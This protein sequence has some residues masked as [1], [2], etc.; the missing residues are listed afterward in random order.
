MTAMIA[1][2]SGKTRLKK[3]RNSPAPSILAASTSPS[4]MLDSK[5]V[6]VM[7]R[8][9]TDRIAGRMTDQMVLTRWRLLITL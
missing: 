8:F 9:H 7:K 4:G 3:V 1:L 2:A 5:K 6:R